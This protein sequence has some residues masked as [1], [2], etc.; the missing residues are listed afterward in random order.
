MSDVTMCD[1][2]KHPAQEIHACP[3]QREINE[4]DSLT[5]ICCVECEQECKDAI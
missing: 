1:C 4:D 5:C 2:G 3:Y